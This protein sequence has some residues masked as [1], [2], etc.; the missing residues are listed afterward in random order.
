MLD[1]LVSGLLLEW[2]VQQE[3]FEY[4]AVIQVGLDCFSL[5]KKKRV[6]PVILT[7]RPSTCFVI[8]ESQIFDFEKLLN[9]SIVRTKILLII[10]GFF[11]TC[12][13]FISTCHCTILNKKLVKT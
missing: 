13:P 6:I 7:L 5:L 12:I 3:C 10:W 11:F 8:H 9:P 1:L 2:V 4:K